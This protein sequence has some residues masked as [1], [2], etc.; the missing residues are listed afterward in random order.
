[1]GCHLWKI[2][3]SWGPFYGCNSFWVT[4]KFL[5]KGYEK[6]PKLLSPFIQNVLRVGNS[7]Q[8]TVLRWDMTYGNACEHLYNTDSSAQYKNTIHLIWELAIVQ[9]IRVQQRPKG[10]RKERTEPRMEQERKK[11]RTYWWREEKLS[12]MDYQLHPVCFN[13]ES[14]TYWCKSLLL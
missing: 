1:M 2:L 10:K 12:M 4:W 9:M 7:S 13:V 5:P 8:Q 3:L 6:L 14:C 11:E